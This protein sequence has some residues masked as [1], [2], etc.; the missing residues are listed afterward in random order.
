MSSATM[1]LQTELHE[2]VARLNDAMVVSPHLDDAVFSCAT[3]LSACAKGASVT[4]L[5]GVPE[6][7]DCTPWDRKSGFSKSSEAVHRR[8]WED[9]AAHRILGA[10]AF[11]LDFLDGQ[12]GALPPMTRVVRALGDFLQDNTRPM[13]AVCI[14]L[15]LLHRDHEYVH[16]ACLQVRRALPDRLWLAYEDVP[17]RCIPG[18][19]QHRLGRLE[20]RGISATPVFP[21]L[22][23]RR[24]KREAVHAYT[25]QLLAF[26]DEDMA[27]LTRPERY[28]YL[29]DGFRGEV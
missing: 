15:G 7:E 23:C 29:A 28:W 13:S 14:P 25:S 11:H 16:E 2:R 6:K 19:L 4:V 8:R 9:C 21:P 10:R 17:Y 22:G 12:Y 5:A 3:F 26:R 27:D 20:A 24:R 18:I 1:H